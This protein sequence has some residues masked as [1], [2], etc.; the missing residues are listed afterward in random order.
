[1]PNIERCPHC[2]REIT[3]ADIEEYQRQQK[4]RQLLNE[5]FYNR[6]DAQ[7]L[8]RRMLNSA[9]G[10][11]AGMFVGVFVIVLVPIV[12]TSVSS[13]F[14]AGIAGPAMGGMPGLIMLIRS[15]RKLDKMKKQFELDHGLNP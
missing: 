1:M 12:A 9:C 5:L 10:M 8:D 7:K 15:I 13:A 4:R 6:P 3:Q 11:L 14:I 2:S